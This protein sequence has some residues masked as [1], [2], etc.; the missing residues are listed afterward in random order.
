[1]NFEKKKNV[2]KK[3]SLPELAMLCSLSF[4]VLIWVVGKDELTAYQESKK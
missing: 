2:S 4:L 1:M 3:T